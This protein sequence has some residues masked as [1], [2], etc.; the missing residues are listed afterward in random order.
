M[1]ALS[2]ADQ[3]ETALIAGDVPDEDVLAMS[4]S[5]MTFAEIA[6][7]VA[8]QSGLQV[9]ASQA[10]D[11]LHAKGVHACTRVFGRGSCGYPSDPTSGTG[12]CRDCQR[13][14]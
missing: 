13:S 9:R 12:W 14:A 11:W 7:R 5:G 8:T 4:Q 1:T 10:E 2:L 6:G 3:F